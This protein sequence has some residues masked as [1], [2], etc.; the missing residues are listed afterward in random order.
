MWPW[1]TRKNKE[2][3]VKK[4]HWKT[5]DVIAMLDSIPVQ[6]LALVVHDKNPEFT[7]TCVTMDELP[8]VMDSIKAY[9]EALEEVERGT[10]REFDYR[11]NV[12]VSFT[13]KGIKVAWKGD[14]G[15]ADAAMKRLG[16]AINK[17][18]EGVCKFG[19][20]LKKLMETK[21]HEGRDKKDVS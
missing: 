18:I 13:G 5:E 16:A 12:L 20:T 3:Q 19:Q 2:I 17:R 8:K 21:N 6:A 1:N 4:K 10:G 14:D 11:N 9:L 15:I 7:P